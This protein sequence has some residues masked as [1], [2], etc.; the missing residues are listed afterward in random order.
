MTKFLYLSVLFSLMTAPAMAQNNSV[1]EVWVLAQQRVTVPIKDRDNLNLY[2]ELFIEGNQDGN[3]GLLYTDPS[4]L[5]DQIYWRISGDN[6]YAHDLVSDIETIISAQ[7]ISTTDQRKTHEIT[8]AKTSTMRAVSYTKRNWSGIDQVAPDKIQH[9]KI[10]EHRS[11]QSWSLG[12]HGVCLRLK[13]TWSKTTEKH[14][15]QERGAPFIR[16]YDWYAPVRLEVTPT[17][18]D[19]CAAN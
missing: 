9:T 7:P 18:I 14:E 1:D 10:R 3:E 16:T 15:T 5:A 2:V 6:F 4:Q 8:S 19:A 13:A 12:D 17:I 11:V